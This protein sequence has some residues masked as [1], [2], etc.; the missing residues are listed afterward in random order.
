MRRFVVSI[1]LALTGVVFVGA[2]PAFALTRTVEEIR[3]IVAAVEGICDFPVTVEQR[4]LRTLVSWSHRGSMVLQTV[5]TQTQTFFTNRVQGVVLDNMP[6]HYAIISTLGP[7]GAGT[8]LFVG[9]GAVWG[10]DTSLG[11]PFFLWVTGA[12]TMHGVYDYKTGSLTVSSKQVFGQSTDLCESLV[13][14][15]KPRH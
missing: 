3:P 4:N 5:R 14:G 1:A 7:G 15:L 13:T 11:Q 9:R 12:V 2:Q 8:I 6:E 10:T